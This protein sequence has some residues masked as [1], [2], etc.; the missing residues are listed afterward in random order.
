MQTLDSL[1]W[2]NTWRHY[3]GYHKHV[4]LT[5]KFINLCNLYSLV[6]L[7]NDTELHIYTK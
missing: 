2:D 1:R 4:Y 5:T 6:S 7:N 3:H